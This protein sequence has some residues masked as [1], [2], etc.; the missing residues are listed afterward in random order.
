MRAKRTL[1]LRALIASKNSSASR[2]RATNLQTRFPQSRS[3]RFRRRARPGPLHPRRIRRKGD[4]NKAT[5]A[6][7]SED[8]PDEDL[9]SFSKSG[10][11]A[12]LGLASLIT[13]AVLFL[14]APL[15]RV[16]K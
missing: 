8:G 2:C 1:S 15:T 4:A 12:E 7:I 5:L 10:H 9:R 6:M 14:A 16:S 11:A 3:F 13:A